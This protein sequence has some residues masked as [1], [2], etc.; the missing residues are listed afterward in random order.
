MILVVTSS[1]Y[2]SVVFFFTVIISDI[3][4]LDMFCI[5]IMLLYT[6]APEFL[7]A[8]MGFLKARLYGLW[9]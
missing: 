3:D 2:N 8:W 5:T 6:N 4:C 1:A 9:S 7:H